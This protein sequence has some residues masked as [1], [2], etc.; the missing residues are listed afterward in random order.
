MDGHSCRRSCNFSGKAAQACAA[1]RDTRTA[2]LFCTGPQLCASAWMVPQPLQLREM[3]FW[4]GTCLA[5]LP[6]L[7]T[8]LFPGFAHCSRRKVHQRLT[9]VSK[10]HIS[11]VCCRPCPREL[12]ISSFAA[13]PH[14]PVSLLNSPVWGGQ[15]HDRVHVPWWAHRGSQRS[16]WGTLGVVSYVLCETEKK[17]QHRVPGVCPATHPE[18]V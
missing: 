12:S 11:G 6:A 8:C 2:L 9:Y 1:S 5:F 15:L 14:C 3:P 7:H 4:G 17:V 13:A 16:L 18:P 10:S